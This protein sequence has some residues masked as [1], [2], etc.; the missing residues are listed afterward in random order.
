MRH[1]LSLA[2]LALGT[3]GP[4]VVATPEPC[5]DHPGVIHPWDAVN[6]II[7]DSL[8][9]TEHAVAKEQELAKHEAKEA[10]EAKEQAIKDKKLKKNAHPKI[11]KPTKNTVINGAV[12]TVKSF[13]G[14]DYIP[15]ATA[16]KLEQELQKAID[17]QL[18]AAK[19]VVTQTLVRTQTPDST[20][21]APANSATPVFI[22]VTE[23]KTVDSD[24][25]LSDMAALNIKKALEKAFAAAGLSLDTLDKATTKSLE[26]C[27]STVMA[28]GGLPEGYSCLTSSGSD[29]AGLTATLNTILE[30]FVGILPNV[31]L[32]SVFDAVTPVLGEL[33]PSSQ[34]DLVSQIQASI[35]SVIATLSGSSVTALEQV[36]ECYTESIQ[37]KGNSSSLECFTKSGGAMSTLQTATNGVLEQFVGVLPASLVTKVKNILNYNLAKASSPN[38][39]LAGQVSSQISNA[40]DSVASTL[41]GN[42]VTLAETLQKC[43]AELIRT[44][45]GKAAQKCITSGQAPQVAST[46]IRG[47]SEQFAGYLPSSFFSDLTKFSAT[48]VNNST[49]NKH[50][51]TQAQAN[52][53][54]DSF[55][56]NATSYGPAFV[57]CFHQV[58]DCVTKAIIAGGDKKA[59]CKGPVAGCT[60]MKK[61]STKST[62]PTT[63]R[64]TKSVTKAARMQAAMTTSKSMITTATPT[65]SRLTSSAT[66]SNERRSYFEGGSGNH[67][68]LRLSR[69]R[70]APKPG[71]AVSV[72]PGA[73]AFF[74]GE[75]FTATITFKNTSP[76]SA[77]DPL[78]LPPGSH[79]GPYA[80]SSFA[81]SDST[82]AP[83]QGH[84][85]EGTATFT[86]GRT[87]INDQQEK[88]GRS[89]STTSSSGGSTTTERLASHSRRPSFASASSL[90]LATAATHKSQPSFF[91]FA[92]STPSNG[93]TNRSV[94][95]ILPRSGEK[96]KP[97]PTRKGL[98]GRPLPP[99][100][101]A[102]PK[103][104]ATGLYSG[105]PRRPGA[106]ANVH[107]RSQSMAFSS[108]DLINGSARTDELSPKKSLVQKAHQRNKLG[109]SMA[110][111][112]LAAALTTAASGRA[113]MAEGLEE[114]P[115]YMDDA[116]F[117]PA[118][119]SNT[120]GR[121]A[122][123]TGIPHLGHDP[124]SPIEVQRHPSRS[125]PDR[126][127]SDS[128]S[129]Y[130]PTDSQASLP[131]RG[132]YGLKRNETMDDI[133]QLSFDSKATGNSVPRPM[134]V[135]PIPRPS[136]AAARNQYFHPPDTVALLWSFAHLEGSFEVDD[137]LVKTNEFIR[138][139]KELVG[140]QG[141]AV[142]GGT[143]NERRSSGARPTAR[144]AGAGTTGGWRDWLWGSS[145]AP[146]SAPGAASLEERKTQTMMD[147][148]IPT[149]SSPPSIL[150]VDLILEPGESKSYT[151]SIRIPADLPPS[152]RG[153]AIKFN[154]NLVV[155]TSRTRLGTVTSPSAARGAARDATSR[156]MRVPIR[157]YNHVG[158]TGA[159]P[160]YDLTN[161]IVYHR[162]EAL[163]T[164]SDD[165]PTLRKA[166]KFPHGRREFEEYAGNLLD[167]VAVNSPEM[168]ATAMSPELK[169]LQSPILESAP[170]LRP[171]R[172]S[173]T[174]GVAI[175]EEDDGGGC[176][177]A[178]EI[179]TRNSQKGR[180]SYDI[181]KDG[182]L[183]SKLTLVKSAYRLG[184][185]VNGS[186]V[187]NSGEGRVLRVSAR[188]ET[189]EL[190]ETTISTRTAN[191][192]RQITRRLHAEHHETTLDSARI[193]FALAIPSG[194]TPDFGTSGVKL[195]W[196]VRLSFLVIPPSPEAPAPNS[197]LTMKERDRVLGSQRPGPLQG[198]SPTNALSRHGRSKSFAYGFEPAVPLTLPPP[199]V[200]TP[201]GAVHLM[202]V[203]DPST[204]H[205]SFRAVPDLGYV[206]V[207]F[208]SNSPEPPPLPGPLQRS[209]TG[210]SLH[211]TTNS[212]SIARQQV[213]PEQTGSVVLVP[214]KVDVVECSI[215]IKVYPGNTPFKPTTSIF[216][217]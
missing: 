69:H 171:E 198:G 121:N 100:P 199:P 163:I 155:G 145:Q 15:L 110:A 133:A 115:S 167:S 99:A 166:A 151:F 68:F 189:H 72:Q 135:P 130:D 204:A 12:D 92:S 94:T 131:G 177:A 13:A 24:D 60:P 156:V 97:F 3:V 66:P 184:E 148:S 196:S 192:I 73:S 185:T 95:S 11:D 129:D 30:Q 54:F 105:G 118:A 2:I 64:T 31:V 1:A 80:S 63:A 212:L 112:Q 90:N 82:A 138:L 76:P 6:Y 59:V 101:V 10:K 215:P 132:F 154:Y 36:Q 50:K 56:N 81:A 143:L 195:Q 179:V 98:I 44:G 79:R 71:L 84:G 142:G 123:P 147:K 213:K 104:P 120:P 46:M 28:A 180:L 55:F 45:D 134:P 42:T 165:E 78:S 205:S 141:A 27:L 65:T 103:R 126:E 75:V 137:S 211:R 200:I 107:A 149:F 164:A 190:V 124:D 41:S 53:I 4:T 209:A 144:G 62:S 186:V 18:A 182:Y 170:S 5:S 157:I 159:R 169:P 208:K 174:R 158:V 89:I 48:Y 37:L 17:E 172:Q 122:L 74:A 114:H 202:P 175:G 38:A 35:K 113:Q 33:L 127:D 23:V 181:N 14:V 96:A 160:F 43:A 86:Q 214:A 139:K 178:V 49:I 70:M 197:I 152:F 140:G 8:K 77:R 216:A 40:I 93:T 25:S 117:P 9:S 188:L 217:A 150:A 125:V 47:I 203:S 168:I 34:V 108:P 51:L 119:S 183:V 7:G 193:G 161:P 207:M 52:K 87:D 19:N 20:I 116:A 83:S 61:T 153:R 111:P 106:G 146:E 21:T 29:G 88:W 32:Q 91:G 109:G 16:E 162:D 85:S 58:Q 26:K 136:S 39:A 191:Q 67:R 102:E 57:T 210:A 176:K 22:T 128:G 201:T 206:P 194:A 187:I 173:R